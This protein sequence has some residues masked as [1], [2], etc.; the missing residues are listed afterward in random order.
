MTGRALEVST[1]P[2]VSLGRGEPYLAMEP[3]AEQVAR[4]E[5][6]SRDINERLEESHDANETDGTVRM[7]CECG[8]K[9][10]ERVVA[11]TT[12]EYEAVRDDPRHFVV[13]HDHVGPH[14]ERV[15]RET[16]RFVVVEKRDG[17]PARIAEEED[18]RG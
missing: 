3:S 18:P 17:T 13:V 4:N 14:A 11:I 5:A 10:C 8:T 2:F 15:V 1:P 6:A 16:G 9:D 7:V 12:E